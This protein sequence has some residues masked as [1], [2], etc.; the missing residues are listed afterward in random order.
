[1]SNEEL[2]AIL[3]YLTTHK[4]K[5]VG[6]ESIEMWSISFAY[7]RI[8]V[9]V[10]HKSA[11]TRLLDATTMSPNAKEEIAEAVKKTEAFIRKMRTILIIRS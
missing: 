10:K 1:M 4:Y 8:G 11:V 7:G 2:T 5:D 3:T 6:N 9:R